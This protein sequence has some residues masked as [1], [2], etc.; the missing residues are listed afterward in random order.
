MRSARKRWRAPTRETTLDSSWQGVLELRGDRET[1]LEIEWTLT[2][3]PDGDLLIAM[4]SDVTERRL[5]ETRQLRTL[6]SERAARAEAELSNQLKD[7][8][9]ATLS[10]ELRN[11]L[12]AILGWASVLKHSPELPVSLTKALD[13]I[14]RNAKVQSH[15]ISDLLDFAG[16]RFGKM[17]LEH[18]LVDASR[19]VRSA[20]DTVSHQANAKRIDLALSA[21]S[22][23]HLVWGDEARLQQIVWNLLTNAIKFTPAGGRVTVTANLVD[24]GFEIRVTDSGRGISAEFLPRLFDRFSQQDDSRTQELR[25]ARHRSDDRAAPRRAARGH[26]HGEQRRRRPRRHVHRLAAARTA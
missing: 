5:T 21:P 17:R 4:V 18:Q 3:D 8:F 2:R 14:E 1:P 10:H 11:P 13:A 9:L 25:G 16:I 6:D 23:V 19:V 12:G 7:Q 24:S 26:D 22:T 15:L 20:V